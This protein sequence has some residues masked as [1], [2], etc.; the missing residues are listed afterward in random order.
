M[1]MKLFQYTRSIWGTWVVQSVKCPTSVQVMIS[2][3]VSS[4]PRRA[5]CWQ[6]RAWS[7]FQILC[8]PLSLPLPYSH[9]VSKINKRGAPGWLSRLSVRLQFRSWSHGSWVRAPRQ[10]LCWQLRPWSL[11]QMLCLCPSPTCALPLSVLKINKHL[12]IKKKKFTKFTNKIQ[13]LQMGHL[14][15]NFMK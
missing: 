7:L 9:A 2:R 14:T 11:F 8:L 12:K 10:A 3:S 15:Y 6:F 4:S 13:N 1:L 5:L